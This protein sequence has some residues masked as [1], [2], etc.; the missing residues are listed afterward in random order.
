MSVVRWAAELYGLLTFAVVAIALVLFGVVWFVH[1]AR[2]LSVPRRGLA[3]QAWVRD[4]QGKPQPFASCD[5]S[6]RDADDETTDLVPEGLGAERPVP[7]WQWG[8]R[9]DGR[10]F[11]RRA[12]PSWTTAL[13]YLPEREWQL[14]TSVIAESA[15]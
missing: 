12:W 4:A 10:P 1:R 15:R 3:P 9:A 11:I 2:A 6:G 14:W 13:A 8:R 5:G 7:V